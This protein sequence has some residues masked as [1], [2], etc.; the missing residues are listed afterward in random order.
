MIVTAGAA[1]AFVAAGGTPLHV[2]AERVDAADTTGAGDAFVG[3]LAVRLRVADDVE[4]AARFAVR[5]GTL[6][7]TRPGTMTAFATADEL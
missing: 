4:A 3:A 7:V 1:G 2:A 6:S 5:A